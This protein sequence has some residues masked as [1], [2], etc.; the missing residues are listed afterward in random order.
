[1]NDPGKFIDSLKEYDKDNIEPKVVKK[2]NK[3]MNNADF[4]PDTVG[5][6]SN[7][8]KSLCMWVRAMH[9]YD[10]VAKGIAPKKAKLAEA[11]TNLEKVE[12]ELSVK[13]SALPF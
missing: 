13:K 9:T 6:V 5:K 4:V 10:R 7:A 3:S 12:A 2:L 11:E 1:M 8:A